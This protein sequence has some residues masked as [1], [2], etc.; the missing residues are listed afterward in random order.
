MIAT[1]NREYTGSWKDRAPRFSTRNA[2]LVT[3][4]LTTF[5]YLRQ[6]GSGEKISKKLAQ[7]KAEMMYSKMVDTG[8]LKKAYKASGSRRHQLKVWGDDLITVKRN[9]TYGGGTFPIFALKNDTLGRNYLPAV[10]SYTLQQGELPRNLLGEHPKYEYKELRLDDFDKEFF[11]LKPSFK[12]DYNSCN[13]FLFDLL[14]GLIGCMSDPEKKVFNNTIGDMV[15]KHYAKNIEDV[16]TKLDAMFDN[17]K[18]PDDR[19]KTP[20]HRAC[21]KAYRRILKF[22]PMGAPRKYAFNPEKLIKDKIFRSVCMKCAAKKLRKIYPQTFANDW[23]HESVFWYGEPDPIVVENLSKKV[24]RFK[25]GSRLLRPGTVLSKDI[26][27]MFVSTII[28]HA[29]NQ[30]LNRAIGLDKQTNK[31][32]EWRLSVLKKDRILCAQAPVDGSKI[33][34]EMSHVRH[35]SFKIKPECKK[36]LKHLDFNFSFEEDNTLQELQTVDEDFSKRPPGLTLL[37]T[38]TSKIQRNYEETIVSNG[39]VLTSQIQEDDE[40]EWDGIDKSK[41]EEYAIWKL[42][43]ERERF[44]EKQIEHERIEK[45]RRDKMAEERFVENRKKLRENGQWFYKAGD[46]SRRFC[47]D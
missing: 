33:S 43:K 32:M 37:E 41:S 2:G 42:T 28:K 11:E 25:D 1:E 30:M 14:Y 44:G 19:Y 35:S 39:E 6:S 26:L 7:K 20:F 8:R 17:F 24:G 5:C 45:E 22:N 31:N 10:P 29:K 46:F 23:W 12:D 38:I 27:K 47:Y 3:F 15:L 34:F 13:K 4:V 36:K 40:S 18:R 16:G 9:N 21:D